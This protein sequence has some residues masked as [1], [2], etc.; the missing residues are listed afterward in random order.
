MIEKSEAHR[1]ALYLA[2]DLTS[3]LSSG[4]AIPAG[5]TTL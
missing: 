4:K 2:S 3:D 1:A 5:T